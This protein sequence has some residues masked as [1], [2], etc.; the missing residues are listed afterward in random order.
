VIAGAAALVALPV[1]LL[2]SASGASGATACQQYDVTG[3][4]MTHQGNNYNPTFD[5]SQ[6]GTNVSGTATV[7]AAEAARAG[8]SGTV[9]QLTHSSLI[10]DALMVS[11]RWPP[12]TTDHAVIVGHYTAT[13]T[14][15]AGAGAL[16]HG[17][18]GPVVSWSGS[19]P[20]TCVPLTAA[21]VLATLTAQ[22]A[23]DRQLGQSLE[24]QVAVDAQ[25]QR[26][27]RWQI[28]EQTQQNIIKIQEDITI[29][30]ATTQDR[31]FRKWD[32]YI[33]GA[34]SEADAA[35]ARP[36]IGQGR[37]TCNPGGCSLTVTPTAYGRGLVKGGKRFP[38]LIT[39]NSTV[40]GRHATLTAKREWTISAHH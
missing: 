38:I 5:F 23:S 10:G 13:V 35:V 33:N 18:A 21:D 1:V 26:V 36:L 11:V 32:E 20:A 40:R 24:Q 3:S 9:G 39:I 16:T 31:A 8:F 12:R 17:K 29:N 22:E 27:Q 6:S 25:N 30:R 28:N 15:A 7:T 37:A 34:G 19:G 2:T 4:W 14:P